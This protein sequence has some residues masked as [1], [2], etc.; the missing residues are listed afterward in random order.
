MNLADYQVN[1]AMGNEPKMSTPKHIK[2]AEQM[3]TS[4]VR[5]FSANEQDLAIKTI[6]ERTIDIRQE[7]IQTLYRN[8]EELLTELLFLESSLISLQNFLNV[9]FDSS[10]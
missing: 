9:K 1:N 7:Q 3:A 6:I 8:K 4:L 10:K 2:I 5:Q